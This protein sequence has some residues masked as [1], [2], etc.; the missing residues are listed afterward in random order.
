MQH[1]TFCRLGL[2]GLARGIQSCC[3]RRYA[4]FQ[5][6][7]RSAI[8]AAPVEVWSESNLITSPNLNS[9]TH[10]LD[11]E[12]NHQMPLSNNH[13]TADIVLVLS[14]ECL[15]H[16]WPL[17]LSET[18]SAPQ[19]ASWPFLLLCHSSTVT[20]HQLASAQEIPWRFPA[21]LPHSSPARQ[22]S[23]TQS[24]YRPG[25]NAL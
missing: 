4:V 8:I 16:Y 12:S 25:L 19:H 11:I 22:K 20:R 10:N 1:V 5:K 9:Q 15:F 6:I 7:E 18:S 21:P 17:F 13:L 24:N 14:T 3:R 2:L 23:T